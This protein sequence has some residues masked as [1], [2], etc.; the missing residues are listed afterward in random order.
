MPVLSVTSYLLAV[1]FDVAEHRYRAA[2]SRKLPGLKQT[3]LE[4]TF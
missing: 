3:V 4:T 2:I 1:S